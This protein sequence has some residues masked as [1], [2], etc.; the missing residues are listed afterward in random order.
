[1]GDHQPKPLV[2]PWRGWAPILILPPLAAL[3]TPAT[4]PRWVYMWAICAALFAGVKWLTWRRTRAPRVPNWRHLAYLFVWPGLD[5]PAFLY[6]NRPPAPRA[7]EWL[8]ATIKLAAG[9]LV[10]WGIVHRIPAE[11]ELLRGWAGM[12]GIVLALH[13]GPFHLLSCAWRSAGVDARRLMNAPLAATSVSE[14]WGRRWNTAFRDL[15]HRFLFRPLTTRLGPRG[16]L[17][18]GFIFSGLIHELAI[19]VPAGAGYGG[20][21]LFFCL[22]VPAMLIERSRWGRALGLGHG[23]HGWLFTTLMLVAPAGLLFHA[24]FVRG[25]VLPFL[26]VLGVCDA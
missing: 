19:S 20:P 8:D 25:V 10:L 3:L 12:I 6:G 13:F 21:T 23:R 15:T 1:M 14:F 24:P 4:W 17:A 7:S 9:I 22:Q 16:G 26:Q 18:A 5:A 11:D 2:P